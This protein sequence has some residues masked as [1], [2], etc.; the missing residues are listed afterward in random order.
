MSSRATVPSARVVRSFQ[1]K[2]AAAGLGTP[3]DAEATGL[4]R[5]AR[6]LL[7]EGAA[8][9]PAEAILAALSLVVSG[10]RRRLREL[11]EDTAL[12]TLTGILDLLLKNTDY[13]RKYEQAS[14]DALLSAVTKLRSHT[15][16]ARHLTAPQ[17]PAQLNDF[18]TSVLFVLIAAAALN[19]WSVVNDTGRVR[20]K[21]FVWMMAWLGLAA[22]WWR[23]VRHW[24]TAAVAWLR[25]SS[26]EEAAE[27]EAASSEQEE[28]Q[29]QADAQDEQ[30]QQQQQADHPGPS[31]PEL[32]PP[33]L[34]GHPAADSVRPSVS[35]QL[36]GEEQPQLPRPGG[37]L[38]Q[39]DSFLAFASG[40][41]PQGGPMSTTALRMGLPQEAWSGGALPQ[42]MPSVPPGLPP[43]GA[44]AAEPTIPQARMPKGVDQMIAMVRRAY[45]QQQASDPYWANRL[46]MEV[47]SIDRAAGLD[48]EVR[49]LLRRHGYTPDA[50]LNSSK[51]ELSALGADLDRLK[52]TAEWAGGTVLQAQPEDSRFTSALPRDLKRAAPEI[53]RS[54]RESAV[55]VR[56]WLL[57][58]FE[59][60]KRSP[61]WQDLWNAAMLADYHIEA[62]ASKG[63]D[64][65]QEVL[66]QNDTIEV[67]L[68]RLAAYIF[69]HRTGDYEAA[70]H[71]LASRAPGTAAD[72]APSWMVTEASS[73]SKAEHQ[74]H[75][76]VKAGTKR[77]DDKGKGRGKDGK[78][79]G[80]G[81]GAGGGGGGGAGG[82]PP[83][84]QG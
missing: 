13:R 31:L 27:S 19:L 11:D 50:L 10:R 60:N 68:R 39:A 71:M 48:S 82:V 37:G 66:A 15:A 51:P 56:D 83:P 79:K 58:N 74:R 22:L 3:D 5:E 42:Q 69:A 59:G 84:H 81:R 46:W 52:R 38:S 26:V 44:T 14:R 65:R 75:E 73:H 43:T 40:A 34:A 53:Y 35:F 28:P 6:T 29:P 18:D 62:A 12:A 2:L 24:L 4:I 49:L 45:A 61:Q 7:R 55:S 23:F 57:Q 16:V 36:P 70:N 21:S 9:Q 17:A 63:E 80:R 8:R 25:G 78:G 30:Q 20:L 1:E 72:I 41:E 47:D 54:V 76:R 67:N 77:Y 64:A 32:P 33:A